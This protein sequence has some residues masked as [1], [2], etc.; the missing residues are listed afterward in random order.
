MKRLNLALLFF[1]ISF[2]TF[3]Q[4]KIPENRDITIKLPISSFAGDIYAESMGIG[5]GLEKMINPSFSFSQEINYIFHVKNNSVLSEDLEDINGVKITTEIRKYLSKNETP[6]SGWFINTELKNI[7]TKSTQEAWTVESVLIQ[8]KIE[9]YRFILTANCGMLFY[10]DKNKDGNLTIELLGG[11]GLGYINAN[12]SADI[13]SLTI[14]S[15]YNSTNKFYP[16]VN[17]DIKIGYVLK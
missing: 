10:W 15:E 11:G 13:E 14:Q 16:C 9:R 6:E 1:F 7:F 4:S 3:G 12:S 2:L 8:N 17:F 5:F